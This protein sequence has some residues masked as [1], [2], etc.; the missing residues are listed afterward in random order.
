MLLRLDKVVRVAAPGLHRACSLVLT[1]AGLYVLRTGSA[2]ALKHYRRAATGAATPTR[3]L[4]A[5][6]R[7]LQAQEDQIAI[8]PLDELARQKDNYFIR[9]EA[10]DDLEVRSGKR[11]PEL[12]IGVTG[13][14]HHLIFPFA[15]LEEVQTLERAL[16]KWLKT[17]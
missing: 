16:G 17:S 14:E 7:D 12:W 2:R 10:V 11:D 6:M 15:T 3:P 4:D 9:L 8:T 1:E 13:S 5:A